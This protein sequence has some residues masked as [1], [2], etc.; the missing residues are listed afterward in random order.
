MFIIS[1]G[2]MSLRFLY[3]LLTKF[4]QLLDYAV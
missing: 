1:A 2:S 4:L 3:G